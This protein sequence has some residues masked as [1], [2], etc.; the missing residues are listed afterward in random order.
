MHELVAAKA[1]LPQRGPNGFGALHF[2]CE[3]GHLPIVRLLL[4]S[5]AAPAD[6][7]D[8]GWTPLHRAALD[9]HAGVVSALLG[10]NKDA[11]TGETLYPVNERDK[12]GDTA[13]HDAC[14]NG[15]LAV[16]KELVAAKC[17]LDAPN[18][19]GQTPLDVA[20]KASRSDVVDFLSLIHI[21]E[22]TRPY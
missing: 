1:S 3:Y 9:G 6:R 18:Q 7:S 15:H 17:Q 22:P 4:R 12:Q 5:R 10:A 16:V 14:R 21:S 8:E 2:A 19:L 13:L 20:S 11:R